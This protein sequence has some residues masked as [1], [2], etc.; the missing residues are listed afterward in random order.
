MRAL[1]KG[2]KQRALEVLY[3]NMYVLYLLPP[4]VLNRKIS[5]KYYCTCISICFYIFVFLYICCF[6]I[7]FLSFYW[8]LLYSFFIYAYLISLHTILHFSHLY[9]SLFIFVY[10]H[11]C[12]FLYFHIII[13]VSF[14]IFVH[15][16]YIF[17][18]LIF[19]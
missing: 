9:F 7:F 3:R 16:C 11:I 1:K 19:L 2:E 12:I 15:F 4:Y 13:I 5:N 18:I 8:M 17:S 14:L 6:Y 10:F